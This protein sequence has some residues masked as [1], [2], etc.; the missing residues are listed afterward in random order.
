MSDQEPREGRWQRRPQK[1][2]RGL[3]SYY[4]LLQVPVTLARLFIDISPNWKW[5]THVF[6]WVQ[7]WFI[8]AGVVVYFL[9][10]FRIRRR[11]EI[12]KALSERPAGLTEYPVEAIIFVNH[13]PLGLDRGVIYFEEGRVGFV[14]SSFSFLLAANDLIDPKEKPLMQSNLL[15]SELE[16]R[17]H[18]GGTAYVTIKPLLGYGRAYRKSMRRFFE[19]DKDA[20]GERQ[21]P[22]ITKYQAV[23]D[24]GEDECYFE[25]EL[26]EEIDSPIQVRH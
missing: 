17:S 20:P 3:W 21:W 14:G 12:D 9:N 16:L 18:G 11:R 25:P 10:E 22:P 4:W 1:A 6:I 24:S 15:L 2:R 5:L 7:L 26:V 19:E 23:V 8:A 13:R